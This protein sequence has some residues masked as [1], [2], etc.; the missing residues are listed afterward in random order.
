[1]IQSVLG[2]G[3]WE[4]K[5]SLFRDALGPWVEAAAKAGVQLAIKPHRS[6]AM[7]KPEQGIWLIDQLKAA[8]TLRLV[9]DYSHYAFRDIAA[10]ATV[11]KALPYTGYVVMKDAV[12][13]DGKVGFLLPGEAGSLPHADILKQFI[14]G[15]YRGEFCCEVSSHVWKR[16]GYDPARAIK[17]CFDN[18]TGIVGSIDET[19]F[20][21]IFNGR[22]LEGWNGKP[23]AWEVRDGAIWCTGQ[24]QEKNWLI[25][26]GDQPGDFDLRMEFRWDRGNSGVQVRSDD[27]GDWQ[28]FGYQVEVARQEAMGLWH[29][30]LLAKDHPKKKQ[31][32]KLATAGESTV[33]AADSAKTVTRVQDAE[34]VKAHFKEEAW[35]RLEIIARGDTLVQK[36][37]GVVFSTLTD[38]DAKMSRRKGF[39]ALQDHGKGCK[40]AFR[41][42]QLRMD[43]SDER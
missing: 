33:L 10:A 15:A 4:R 13:L 28:V 3:E 11:A 32:H 18:M 16:K 24:S 42:L 17:T 21:P 41:K 8:I 6:H 27:L 25:W 37:N 29:H 1:M 20:V 12:M 31:R 39:I 38:K 30:S 19:G 43:T 2:G 34:V 40:V 23:D 5:K 9:Y 35:N 36:I 14:E 7:S 22:D 26:R